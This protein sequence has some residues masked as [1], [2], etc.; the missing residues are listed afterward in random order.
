LVLAC[1]GVSVRTQRTEL[2]KSIRY[3]DTLVCKNNSE[4]RF[5]EIYRYEAH[6]PLH[7]YDC[8]ILYYLIQ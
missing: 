4:Q 5:F 8:N 6:K 2:S 1:H 3:R 7:E